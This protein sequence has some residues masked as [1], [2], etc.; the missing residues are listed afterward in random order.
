MSFHVCVGLRQECVLSSLFFI[1]YTNWINKLSRTDECV[2]IGKRKISRLLFADDIILLGSS[3]SGFQHALN[4]F[5]DTCDT[6][7]MKINTSKT[8]VLFLSRN[9]F[10]CSLQVG[11][12][13]L[14]HVE[15]LKYFGVAF[16]SD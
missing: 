15:K 4:G 9:L 2:T 7:G 12:V 5:A 10:Q 8:E 16:T 13:S 11:G 3:E 6:A 1:I 14:K